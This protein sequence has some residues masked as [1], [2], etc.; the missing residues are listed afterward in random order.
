MIKS[1]LTLIFIVLVSGTFPAIGQSTQAPLSKVEALKAKQD[2]KEEKKRIKNEKAES[3][4]IARLEKQ[5][6]V[7]EKAEKK[8]IQELTKVHKN[9]DK[10]L[11]NKH[12][13]E[14]KLAKQRV[15][16]EQAKL[17]KKA[18]DADLAKMELAIKRTE[19]DVINEEGKVA[20][21]KRDIERNTPRKEKEEN[22][23][24]KEK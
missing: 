13:S 8:R 4:A 16:F 22:R 14:I 19:I 12:K 24:K 10:A 23:Y 15:K 20:N 7:E 21:F 17:K 18:T 11:H 3:K 2:L 1:F 9:Y 5:K 6:S